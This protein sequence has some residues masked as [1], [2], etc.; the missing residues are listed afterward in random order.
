M[1]TGTTTLVIGGCRSGKSD[2]GQRLAEAAGHSRLYVATCVPAD[3][4]MHARVKR[5]REGRGERWDTIEEPLDIS[6]VILLKKQQYD[7]VLIDCLTLWTTQLTLAEATD[8]EVSRRLDDL[9]AAM[10]APGAPLI[11]VTNEVGCGI[12]PENALARR[13]RD[14]AGQVNRTVAARAERVVWVVA[15]IPVTIKPTGGGAA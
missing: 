12:V 15:G 4:E 8:D 7:V 13:F 9:A 5:H 10:A 11:F 1:T 6:D 3:D 14:L 2:H